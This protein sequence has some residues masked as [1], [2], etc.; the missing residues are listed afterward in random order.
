MAT[1][2]KKNQFV[3][4]FLFFIGITVNAQQSSSKKTIWS[5]VFTGTFFHK[6]DRRVDEKMFPDQSIIDD[7]FIESLCKK[8]LEDTS[9]AFYSEVAKYP[10]GHPNYPKNKPTKAEVEKL[11]DRNIEKGMYAGMKNSVWR[12]DI[13]ALMALQ[14]WKLSADSSLTSHISFILPFANNE[15]A[16]NKNTLYPS[17]AILNEP[18]LFDKENSTILW[19]KNVIYRCNMGTFSDSTYV[20]H[21]LFSSANTNLV[22]FFANAIN[23]KKIPAYLS[24]TDGVAIDPDSIIFMIELDSFAVKSSKNNIPSLKYTDVDFTKINKI[25]VFQ[26]FYYIL[27]TNAMYSDIIAIRPVTKI[28]NEYNNKTEELPLYWIY[29]NGYTPKYAQKL[30]TQE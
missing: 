26:R 25:D 5:Q 6:T 13:R 22:C 12:T 20:G 10:V 7:L 4:V 30:K 16:K 18:V 11:I 8:A 23:Q 9:I 2:T 29:V 15:F 1:A 28:V 17:V 24:L 3:L 14:E 27:E 19:D 21:N